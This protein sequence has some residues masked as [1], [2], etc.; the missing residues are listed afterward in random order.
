MWSRYLPAESLGWD[1]ATTSRRIRA[2]ASLICIFTSSRSL[3]AGKFS[4]T[5][6]VTPAEREFGP[7]RRTNT[8]ARF[9]RRGC[10]SDQADLIRKTEIFDHPDVGR[11]A[12]AHR[13][14]GPQ[15]ADSRRF[16]VGTA[17]PGSSEAASLALLGS[18]AAHLRRLRGVRRAGPSTPPRRT[19]ASS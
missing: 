8:V 9:H 13:A 18:R 19:G 4:G 10:R 15:A 6:Q 12:L 3:P 1:L 2:P 17:E 16:L 5:F 14:F 11:I 7:A